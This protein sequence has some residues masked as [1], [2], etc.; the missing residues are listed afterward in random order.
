MS[1]Y[2]YNIVV[3]ILANIG[4]QA[5]CPEMAKSA[6]ERLF[7]ADCPLIQVGSKAELVVEDAEVTGIFDQEWIGVLEKE[8][9]VQK[10]T[11][12]QET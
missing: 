7:E 12:V 3:K 8:P 2:R 9:V 10:A 11:L 1:Q 4:V 6:V 5:P